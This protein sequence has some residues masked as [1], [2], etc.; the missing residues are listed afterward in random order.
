LTPL[1]PSGDVGIHHA[2]SSAAANASSDSDRSRFRLIPRST[3]AS[4]SE[5]AA[6]LTKLWHKR[7]V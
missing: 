4:Q 2:F 6:I 7:A 3:S 1:Q 5:A